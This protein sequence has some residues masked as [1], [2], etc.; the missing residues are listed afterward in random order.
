MR[1]ISPNDHHRTVVRFFHVDGEISPNKYIPNFCF[2]GSCSRSVS[3]R[4]HEGVDFQIY[5]SG[6][7]P[8]IDFRSLLY[9]NIICRLYI[10]RHKM[11][12]IFLILYLM[13]LIVLCIFGDNL[14]ILFLILL[15]VFCFFFA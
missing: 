5:I 13:F 3:V 9:Y 7:F 14:L 6:F 1:N 15:F 4:G 12:G 10:R 8:I 11:E 2:I